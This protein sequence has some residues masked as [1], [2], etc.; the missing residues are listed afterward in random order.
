MGSAGDRIKLL[1]SLPG[2]AASWKEYMTAK[3][4][5]SPG[6][7]PFQSKYKAR[8][9]LVQLR[10]Q[11]EKITT[12][13]SDQETEKMII[14]SILDF[15]R[16]VN[17]ANTEE[18]T[19]GER[20]LSASLRQL[21]PLGLKPSYVAATVDALN[22]IGILWSDW[23]EHRKAVTF[24]EEARDTYQQYKSIALQ[25]PMPDP[26]DWET[27]SQ[28]TE[29]DRWEALET[30]YT[31]SSYY[32]AQVY[33]ALKL[34]DKSAE[35]CLLTLQRQLKHKDLNKLTWALD[36][37]TLSQYYF[38]NNAFI[39]AYQC[40]TSSE[41]ML[42]NIE[43]PGD[44]DEDAG[45]SEDRDP[46]RR[47][48]ADVN[49]IWGKFFLA[50][51]QISGERLQDDG[52]A[53]KLAELTEEFKALSTT[54]LFEGLD[55]KSKR[56][57]IPPNFATTYEEART[58]F[59][60]GL[61]TLTFAKQFFQLD[62]FVTDH[63]LLLQDMSQLYNRF[64][65]FET[66][67]ARRYKLHKRRADSLETIVSAKLSPDHYLPQLQQVTYELATIHE[68]MMDA[69]HDQ[70]EACPENAEKMTL[71]REVWNMGK[72]AVDLYEEFVK[73]FNDPSTKR[74]PSPFSDPDDARTVMTAR[75]RLAWLWSKLPVLP[76]KD[77]LTSDFKQEKILY[78]RKSFDQYQTIQDYYLTHGV[79]E[80]DDEIEVVTEM[81]KLLPE[82][83]IQL[84][85]Q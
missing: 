55:A 84:Q 17:H 40:L 37:M 12:T 64:A 13:D 72:K 26:L 81:C 42:E 62:G 56:P 1:D 15:H 63:V 2:F 32:L 57:V 76:R 9:I 22:Q 70:Y 18:A 16:G 30:L 41:Y 60:E 19:Q 27:C 48:K 54:P 53:G 29:A 24:F 38:Q 33:G 31:Y 3:D 82:Q 7:A 34:A 71:L 73:L 83:I 77:G 39:L 4:E 47:A 68:A 20:L 5:P 6:S 46:L 65:G 61:S 11:V 85:R 75:I 51:L 10:E 43:L 59:L 66:D 36:C 50:A 44:E 23:N 69:R 21:R 25:P 80:F 8:S 78:L 79:P 67:P 35:N 14:L 28:M 49:W 45:N 58:L 52:D 74:Q